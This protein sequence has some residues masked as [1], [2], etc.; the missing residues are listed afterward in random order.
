[1][2]RQ[3]KHKGRLMM[4]QRCM[5]A[6]A[7]IVIAS[8]SAGCVLRPPSSVAGLDKI[9]HAI[10]IYAE[11]RSFDHLYGLFPGANGLANGTAAEYTHVD[12]D[13]KPLDDL[14][15]SWKGKNVDPAF[16]HR[17]PN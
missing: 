11:N 3:T 7:V 15:P 8:M 10:V 5:R 13:G 14:P 17:M 9:Q 6:L 4:L 1:M 16:P 2:R 12:R